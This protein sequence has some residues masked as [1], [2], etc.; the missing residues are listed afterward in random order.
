MFRCYMHVIRYEFKIRF[1]FKYSHTLGEFRLSRLEILFFKYQLDSR[2]ET[3]FP[4]PIVQTLATKVD[5]LEIFRLYI[6]VLFR[7]FRMLCTYCFRFS[8][9]YFSNPFPVFEY[10]NRFSCI[11]LIYVLM[12]SSFCISFSVQWVFT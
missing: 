7:Y 12:E 3:V 2:A 4:E 8:C 10:R 1:F 5:F 6:H 9:K 11:V